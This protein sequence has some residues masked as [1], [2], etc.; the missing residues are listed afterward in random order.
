MLG[1][2]SACVGCA[3]GGGGGG[4]GVLLLTILLLPLG[5]VF[6]LVDAE[7]EEGPGLEVDCLPP[8]CCCPPCGGGDLFVP[9][10]S[11]WAEPGLPLSPPLG[12]GPW[13]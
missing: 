4:G 13:P 1:W 7:E 3:G 11:L 12:P 10:L 2:E 8:P 6:G 9:S 5:F